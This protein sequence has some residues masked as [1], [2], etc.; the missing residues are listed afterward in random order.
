MIK[1]Q[2]PRPTEYDISAETAINWVHHEKPAFLRETVARMRPAENDYYTPSIQAGADIYCFALTN[3][4]HNMPRRCRV[5]F[6]L[7]DT[8]VQD[9]VNIRNAPENTHGLDRMVDPDSI[10]AGKPSKPAR[11]KRISRSAKR[12]IKRRHA[13]H[14]RAK[15]YFDNHARWPKGFR[16]KLKSWL[17]LRY[18]NN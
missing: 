12:H 9:G 14:R 18:A 7:K 11:P 2:R 10:E 3:V 5:W 13:H 8:D 16:Q 4:P 6:L 1:P 17:G 15:T